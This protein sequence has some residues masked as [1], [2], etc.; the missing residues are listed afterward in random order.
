M[1]TPVILE[2][3]P[4]RRLRHRF[5]RETLAAPELDRLLGTGELDL[6]VTDQVDALRVRVLAGLGVL[7]RRVLA[8]YTAAWRRQG[9]LAMGV[10][11]AAGIAVGAGV[12]LIRAEEL[13]AKGH[14]AA[15]VI[16][17][18]AS[19]VTIAFVATIVRI[20]LDMALL[21]KLR[22]RYRPVVEAAATREQLL[23]TART[24]HE[25]VRTV[26]GA[27]EDTEG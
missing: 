6:T 5:L 22:K 10:G 9:W 15:W 17:V 16:L 7:D 14:T 2:R 27:R 20:R 1:T 12:S 24:I 3:V 13:T 21:R 18:L 25:E 4:L 23:A 8:T 26:A 11:I 19:L